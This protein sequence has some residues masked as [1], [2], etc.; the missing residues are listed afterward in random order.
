METILIITEKPRVAEKL[1]AALS[2]GGLKQKALHGVKYYE[3]VKAGKRILISPAVGHIYSLK[4]T[5]PG[6]DYPVFDVEWVP[7]YESSDGA[8]YTKK[9]LDTLKA[10]SKETNEVINACD[11]D[12][13]GSL[14]GGNIIRHMIKKPARRMLFS[15]LTKEDL[16]AAYEDLK[17]LDNPQIEAGEARHILDWFWGINTSRALMAAMRRAGAFRIM[18]IGRVQGPALA[19]LA[20]KEIEISKFVP[21]AYW[22][23]DA[24]LKG[25]EFS[26][27]EGNIED[28]NK[29]KEI[30][31][32]V[33]KGAPAGALITKVEEKQ[34]TANPPTPFDLTSLELE[35]YRAFGF[36][37]SLT[38]QI[39]QTL[40]EDALISY[41]RTSSQKLSE[42]LNLK[43]IISDIGKN[44]AYSDSASQLMV[45]GNFKPNEGTK[46]DPAHPAIH[47]TG[48]LARSLN[49]QQA[50]LYDLIVRRFLACFAPAAKRARMS[51]KADIGTVGFSASGTRTVEKNWIEIYGKYADFDEVTLPKFDNGERVKVDKHAME[52]KMTKPPKRYTEA[53]LVKKLEDDDLGTKATRSEIIETLFR[54][55]YC[56][57]KSIEV[58]ALGLSVYEALTKHVDDILSEQLT[59]QFEKEME[60]IQEGK[61]TKDKVVAEGKEMLIKILNKFRTAEEAIG[62]ELLGALRQTQRDE[63][64]LGPCPL[65][66]KEGRTGQLQI[67]R[68]QYGQFVGCGAY[69]NCRNIY[70]LPKDG[71]IKPM[72]KTCPECGTPIIKVIR[73]GK[74]PFEMC[75]DPKCKTKASWASNKNYQKPAAPSA[76]ASASAPAAP[77]KAIPTT[78]LASFSKVK[79]PAPAIA[80]ITKAAKT[81]TASAAAKTKPASPK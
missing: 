58:S 20:Q 8:D 14:I 7:A 54:R 32:K 15:T 37:P 17:P 24:F 65:C 78:A 67:R 70:P 28:E 79:A 19:I 62:K 18:S 77:A 72:G 5:V 51:V 10:L 12:I 26:C 80:P 33:S 61:T 2:E 43:K 31:D 57:G 69:P 39:A 40:Y 30:Y 21:T 29:A 71:L 56:S 9:Y 38:L 47:P 22:N 81:K 52:K 3:T 4:Q 23:I 6:S 59:R 35:A 68:S 1:A 27:D 13:E 55:G 64:I 76:T 36:K 45:K 74:K 25:A 11:W 41:P 53:S 42:K 50:K 66:A 46:D 44:P 73:K 63:S 60:E 34:F 16:V 48:L 75:V 49:A